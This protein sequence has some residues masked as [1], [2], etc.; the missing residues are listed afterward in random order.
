MLNMNGDGDF[1]DTTTLSSLRHKIKRALLSVKKELNHHLESINENTN[2]IQANYEYIAELDSRIEKL[3]GKVDEV[4]LFLKQTRNFHIDEQVPQ[5]QVQPLSVHEKRVF[6]LLYTAPSMLC[7]NDIA[8]ALNMSESL[9]RSYV[10]N[11][12]EK[13]I[14]VVK[15]YQRGKPLIS[16]DAKF[17]RAQAEFNIV[18]IQQKQLDNFSI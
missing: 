13:G 14:P 2:E 6:V 15:Q 10:T 4:Q 5:Y 9:A 8:H 12:I 16:L 11:L 1:E 7:Y 18:K 3:N 17:K